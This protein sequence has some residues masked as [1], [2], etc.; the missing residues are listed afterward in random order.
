MSA[1]CFIGSSYCYISSVLILLYIYMSAYCYVCVLSSDSVDFGP[2][3]A[4]DG[5]SFR[6][7]IA[8]QVCSCVCVYVCVCVCVCVCVE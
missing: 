8:G 3:N 5:M 1:Y 2:E 4:V 7:W 6:D